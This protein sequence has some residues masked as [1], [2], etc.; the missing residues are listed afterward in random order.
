MPLAVFTFVIIVIF[1]KPVKDDQSAAEE[2]DEHVT[3]MSEDEVKTTKTSTYRAKRH[4]LHHIV[5]MPLTDS[6]SFDNNMIDNHYSL[7]RRSLISI[8]SSTDRRTSSG[9]RYRPTNDIDD[10]YEELRHRFYKNPS[11]V[12]STQSM[13]AYLKKKTSLV[14]SAANKTDDTKLAEVY[15]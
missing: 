11:F 9:F 2:N 5:P 13:N 10:D 8:E 4:H 12:E 15:I 7:H 14:T 1:Y 6:V 3:V